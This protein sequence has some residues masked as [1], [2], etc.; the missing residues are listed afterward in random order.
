MALATW[1]VIGAFL[2]AWAHTNLAVLETFFTP[3]HG[4]LYSGFAAT[5]AWIA[6]QAVRAQQAGH[7]GWD[8]VPVGY[9]WGMIGVAVFAV[10]AI[11]DMLW[12][13]IFGIEQGVE[14][15]VSPTHQILLV[16]TL[17]VMSSPFR[18][19][20]VSDPLDHRPRYRAFIPALLSLTYVSTFVALIV[21]FLTT[22][23]TGAPAGEFGDGIGS[24]LVTTVLLVAPVL[25]MASRWRLPLGVATTLFTVMATLLGAV[26]G[27]SRPWLPVA[28]AAA[29]LATDLLVRRL[30]P[31]AERPA[32]FWAVGFVAPL[33]LWVPWFTATALTEGITWSVDLWSGT[34]AWTALLGLALSMLMVPPP[35]ER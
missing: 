31:S 15:A 13:T 10:G 14:A 9:G 11:G 16:G 30:A 26:D 18:A 21:V 5:A 8:A 2:D 29:G 19:A 1:F 23:S 33:L 12:H 22:F 17:L 27:W 32:A 4:V 24:I 35:V 7:R 34:L 28:A 3:W 25:L 6:W 20:W